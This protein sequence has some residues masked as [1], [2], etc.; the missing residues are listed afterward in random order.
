MFVIFAHIILFIPNRSNCNLHVR[1]VVV[2]CDNFYLKTTSIKM[3]T[4]LT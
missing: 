1:Q 4:D 3:L 2:A